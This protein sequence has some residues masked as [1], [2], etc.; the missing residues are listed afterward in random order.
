MPNI[1]FELNLNQHPKNAVNRS[2]I[3]AKNVQLSNDL[4]CLQS[5]FA[6][7]GRPDLDELLINKYIAGYIPCN[8]E[9]I[10]FIAP[11][12]YKTQL[13]EHPEGIQIDIYRYK[14]QGDLD[15]N[16]VGSFDNAKGKIVY[17]KFVWHGGKLKGTFTYNI[18]SHLIIAV[19]ESDTLTGELIP[20]KTINLGTYDSIATDGDNDLG[21]LDSQIINNPEVKLPK[22]DYDYA[23]GIAYKGYYHF[24]IRYKINN[25]DYTKWYDIGFPIFVDDIDKVQLFNYFLTHLDAKRYGFGAVDFVSTESNVCNKTLQI[26]LSDLDNRYSTFQLGFVCVSKTASHAY[27]SLDLSNINSFLIDVSIM[28]EYS[29][30]S[31]IFQKYNYYDVKNAINYKNRLYIANYKD[32]NFDYSALQNFVN[33]IPLTVVRSSYRISNTN[34]GSSQF[35]GSINVVLAKGVAASTTVIDSNNINNTIRVTGNYS[36]RDQNSLFF[37][38]I[39]S[40]QG[41]DTYNVDL[42]NDS[43]IH[44]IDTSYE[45][46]FLNTTIILRGYKNNTRTVVDEETHYV[47]YQTSYDIYISSIFT[48]NQQ[49]DVD[50]TYDDRLKNSR[51]LLPGNSY[52]IYIHF[53]NKYGEYTDGI[54]L[55]NYVVNSYFS[56]TNGLIKI[57]NDLYDLSD[58]SYYL[59]KLKVNRIVIPDSILKN[60]N[61]WFL[62]YE[63][64]EQTT[65]FYGVLTRFDFDQPTHDPSKG[66]VDNNYSTPGENHVYKFYCADIDLLEHLELNFNFVRL[67][68]I[69]GLSKLN[70]ISYINKEGDSGYIN[71]A[72]IK[73]QFSSDTVLARYRVYKII[74]AIYVPAH[75]FSKNN[76]YRGSYIKLELNDSIP[77]LNPSLDYE[78]VTVA[79]VGDPDT[80][81]ISDNKI[82]I[83]F[84]NIFNFYK[85]AAPSTDYILYNDS[86]TD[87]PAG[88]NGHLTYNNFLMYN[89][90]KVIL[91]PG[92]NLLLNKEYQSYISSDVFGR[93]SE[94][95]NKINNGVYCYP[96]A[97]ISM[98]VHSDIWYESKCFK[99]RPEIII[100]RKEEIIDNVSQQLFDFDQNTIVQPMNSVDLFT[101][102]FGSQDTSIPITYI[103]HFAEFIN[104]FNKRLIRSNP[105]ADESF[106]NSW[107]IFS[108]E[109]YKDITENKG[110]ITNIIAL[111]TTLLVH[112]EHGLFMFDRDNTLQNGDGNTM[113]LAMPDIFDVD[114][115]EVIASQ[116]GSCGL[117]DNEAWILD[118]FG[119]IFYDNDAHRFYKFGSKKIEII[120]SSIEQFVNK[121]KPHK[122]RFIND[123]ESNRILVDMLYQIDFI[124]ENIEI[125]ELTLSYNTKINK[126]ISTHDYNF[127]RGFTT[128]QMTYFILD[129]PEEGNT[130]IVS[131]IYLI[132]RINAIWQNINTVE[133]LIYSQ[134]ENVRNSNVSKFKNC[135]ISIIV[136]DRYELIKTLEYLTWKLYKIKS[137]IGT[138]S[139]YNFEAREYIKEPYSGYTLRVYND[140]VDTGTIDISCSTEADKNTS[141][142][143]YKKAWWQFGN[144]NFNYLRDIKNANANLKAQFMSRLY[145]N[146]FII[147]FTFGDV[148]NRVEFETLDC[149]LIS[150]RTI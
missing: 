123:S 78:M 132:N 80:H 106:E 100:S 34:P 10:L 4:S 98:V 29:I 53:V 141:V 59:Y 38:N 46:P 101:E 61:G 7:K 6:I 99:T 137:N 41:S 58:Y 135:S 11:K 88:Y 113:Q 109:A 12:D 96:V 148:S 8:K 87:L 18:K 121:Y 143:N 139:A 17:N 111:G 33:T 85:E 125:N 150:N 136:N 2:L 129:K 44:T 104:E 75:D 74:K 1:N 144:W 127:D 102:R 56:N 16:V 95:D 50:S 119:Y 149:K 63:K 23:S 84:T 146:Y 120:D 131:N 21:L 40:T 62:S 24:F 15:D 65:K 68:L 110:N 55:T 31:F 122:V 118:E 81:Y 142:M 94:M 70:N 126:W 27:K 28:E 3:N 13:T 5:E 36:L 77:E 39:N 117:Q 147:E 45:I 134:F 103:N 90:N 32:S 116:L 9:F 93:H 91:N 30:E 82:L 145:G 42:P 97:L 54:L 37:I 72:N 128:K 83:K 57:N 112:T 114:Y 133:N 115:K 73:Q 64:Y 52:K 26:Y 69:N 79:L 105:I 92:Y 140:Q 86:E 49:S 138:D 51:T 19:A 67:L 71:N 130:N 25:V 14:E 47:L 107:K 20:L 35:T 89:Y 124:T 66:F 43:G 76:D 108:P 22:I 48:Q 60:Y